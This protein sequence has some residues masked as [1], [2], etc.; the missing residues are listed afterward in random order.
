[1][2]WPSL[3]VL[4]AMSSGFLLNSAVWP[5]YAVRPTRRACFALV[6]LATAVSAAHL[7]YELAG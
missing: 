5:R 2:I 1:M 4:L 7:A 3:V 6:A